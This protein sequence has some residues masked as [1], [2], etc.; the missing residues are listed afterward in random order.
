MAL[1][2]SRSRSVCFGFSSMGDAKLRLAARI[3]LKTVM[4]HNRLWSCAVTWSKDFV[5]DDPENEDTDNGACDVGYTPYNDCEGRVGQIA[6]YALRRLKAHSHSP[7]QRRGSAQLYSRKCHIESGSTCACSAL[8]TKTFCETPEHALG[9]INDEED[10]HKG[11]Q[12]KA[13]DSP[14]RERRGERL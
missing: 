10:H 14:H 9:K 8:A 13:R 12:G 3:A 2:G 1:F 4:Y 11:H 6:R 7:S 5:D